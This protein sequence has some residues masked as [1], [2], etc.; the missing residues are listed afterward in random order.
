MIIEAGKMITYNGMN[1][2]VLRVFKYNG[3]LKV[4][5]LN[6]HNKNQFI[7]FLTELD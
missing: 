7:I 6:L 3:D 2:R 4:E 1:H 5:L